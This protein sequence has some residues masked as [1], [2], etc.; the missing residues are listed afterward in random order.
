MSDTEGLSSAAGKRADWRLLW[1]KA[2]WETEGT[3][4]NDH[5][6]D[7]TVPPALPTQGSKSVHCK[8]P[9]KT[10]YIGSN[11]TWEEV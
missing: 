9:S 11:A 10:L 7:K 4:T 3:P 1:P 6:R 8:K 2:T 5:F